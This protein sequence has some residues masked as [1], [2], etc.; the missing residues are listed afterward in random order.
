MFQYQEVYFEPWVGSEYGGLW[1]RKVLVVGESHYDTWD[2]EKHLLSR[3]FTQECVQEK[4]DL[5]GGARFWNCIKNRLGG[6]E[7]ER[8]TSDVFWNKVAFYNYIQ[9]PVSGGPGARPTPAQWREA[10][11]P[12]REVLAILRPDRVLFTGRALWTALTPRDGKQPNIEFEGQSLPLEFFSLNDP[13]NVY[14]TA[15]ANPRSSQFIRLL[16]PILHE[17]VVRDHEGTFQG[18]ERLVPSVRAA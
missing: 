3:A 16:S 18:G 11:V 6:E 8:G 7:H 12:L 13:K 4:I 9:S 2:G 1:G 17:F 10:A 14:V 5:G 15:T